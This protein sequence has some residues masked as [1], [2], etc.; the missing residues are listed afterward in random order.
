[1]PEEH[2]LY[3]EEQKTEEVRSKRIRAISGSIVAMLF[4][5]GYFFLITPPSNSEK[6][7]L[8]TVPEGAVLREVSA[9]LK[10]A[11]VI[12]SEIAFEFFVILHGGEKKIVSGDYFFE[13]GTPVYRVADQIVRHDYGLAQVRV[14]LPEGMNRSEMSIVLAKSLPK[15][16]A[17]LF[18]DLTKKDEGYLF[19][20]TYFFFPTTTTEVVVD[21]LKETFAKKTAEIQTLASTSE[22]TFKDAVIMASIVEKEASGDAD[23]VA[24]AGILWHRIAIGMPL[25]ADATVGYVLGKGRQDI[26]PADL[27]FESPYNTYLHK[28]LPPGPISNP[29][30]EALRA[31]FPDTNSDY[32]YYLHDK[33]GN[34]HYAKTFAEHKANIEKYL[35]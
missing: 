24:I 12:R 22:H 23:R 34:A 10:D 9:S 31:A 27:K 13:E 6:N 20:D 35:K 15:F 28:G 30:I 33:D 2:F 5:A 32:L 7:T 11:H 4:L 26:R 25:Q 3:Q 21:K 29:G 18:T 19:P 16:D 8:V 14:T 17:K 1:M